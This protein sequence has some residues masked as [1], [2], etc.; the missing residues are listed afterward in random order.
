MAFVEIRGPFEKFVYRRQ[1]SAVIQ[2]EAV[3]F[4]P[5]CSGGGK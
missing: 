2:G 3:T 5:K 4:M 1:C